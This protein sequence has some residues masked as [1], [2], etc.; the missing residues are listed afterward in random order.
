MEALSGYRTQSDVRTAISQKW[1]IRKN[2]MNQNMMQK[3]ERDLMTMTKVKMSV[4]KMR[5]VSW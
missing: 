4:M 3:A 5:M 2:K 1:L